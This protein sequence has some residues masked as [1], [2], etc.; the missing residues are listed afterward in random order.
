MSEKNK[1]LDAARK[2][3]IDRL[4]D[5]RSD[6]NKWRVIAFFSLLV[7]LVSVLANTYLAFKSDIRPYAVELNDSKVVRIREIDMLMPNQT[8]IESDL[9]AWIESCRMVT[10]D[11]SLQNKFI[12]KCF[13]YVKRG[14]S[15]FN[16]LANWFS[17]NNPHE[18]ASNGKRVFAVPATV[19][20]ISKNVFEILWH[21]E[22]KENPDDT[23]LKYEYKAFVS[24]GF[25]RL[26]NEK[27]LMLNP[28]GLTINELDWSIKND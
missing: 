19:T 10:G 24:I 2:A 21:E 25:E 27:E 23:P 1:L 9:Q 17:S 12:D 26:T 13:S 11:P 18:S 7:A 22:V 4:K 5:E 15:G 3:Y 20:A 8:R 16:S 6:K 28:Y 14:S